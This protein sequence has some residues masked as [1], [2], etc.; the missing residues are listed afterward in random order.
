MG[1]CRN[2]LKRNRFWH[3]NCI[4]LI[5]VLINKIQHDILCTFKNAQM[6]HRSNQMQTTYV[7][8]KKT[9]P[10]VGRTREAQFEMQLLIFQIIYV[11]DVLFTCFNTLHFHS[12]RK[13]FIFTVQK[14]YFVSY[15][16][17]KRKFF[18]NRFAWQS[19]KMVNKQ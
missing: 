3:E 5:F 15:R 6:K 9:L 17:K 10:L 11:H 12:Y 2:F 4:Y 16:D 18:D 7:W 14:L 19:L 8:S 1:V 13:K